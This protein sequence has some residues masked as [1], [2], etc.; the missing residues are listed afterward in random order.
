MSFSKN[1]TLAKFLSLFLILALLSV[2]FA[3][4]MSED[5]SSNTSEP[6]LNLNLSDTTDPTDSQTEEVTEPTE[7]NENMGTVTQQ[8]NVRASPSTEATVVTTLYAG[9]RVEVSQQRTVIGTLWGYVPAESG[10]VMMEY[11]QMDV[12]TSDTSSDTDSTTNATTSAT[13]DTDSDSTTNIKGVITANN[14]NI[15]S[16]ASTT[17][18]VVGSYD[19]GDVVTILETSNGW[20]RTSKGWIKM[21]YVNTPG[22][23][24]TTTTTTPATTV[25]GIGGP[26]VVDRG[27]VPATQ[28]NVRAAASQ[29]SDKVGTLSYGA[30]VEILE[31]SGTWGRTADGWISLNYV[32]QDG[33]TGT[34]TATG[35]ITA[36]ALRVRSGPGTA[37]EVVGSY[38]QGDS[39]TILEQFTYG[40]TTWGC[41]SLGW[42][43]MDY[44]NT[45]STTTTTTTTTTSTQTGTVVVETLRIRSGAG[46]DYAVV[47]S[48]SSGDVVTILAT[49]QVDGETWGQISSGWISLSYVA[50]S[51]E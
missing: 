34:N 6:S 30:R 7:L 19:K 25:T 48:L 2:T 13:E 14:L 18:T 26:P 39:V 11:I 28:L 32:Y 22:T 29:D 12:D 37:Y 50:I 10:W 41:T 3:A 43:S 1:S 45:G 5:D 24:T 35:T 38:E 8:L 33:T 42:I 15:R 4:C 20:G 36:T 23:T 46:T 49:T 9:D 17:G 21:D 47:G 40:T 51:T 44:V 27:M 31:K 16:E